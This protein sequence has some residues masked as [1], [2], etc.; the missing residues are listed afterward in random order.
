MKLHRQLLAPPARP[1]GGEPPWHVTPVLDVAQAV[2][3][4]YCRHAELGPGT[5]LLADPSR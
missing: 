1:R 2:F 4:D 5:R 3:T